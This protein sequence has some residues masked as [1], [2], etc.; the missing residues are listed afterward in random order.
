MAIHNSKES[1]LTESLRELVEVADY[2]I[3]FRKDLAD[4]GSQGCYGYPAAIL[5]LNICDAIGQFKLGGSVRNHFNIL[6]DSGYYNLEL[7]NEEIKSIYEGY[8]CCL[9]HEAVLQERF[10][11]HIGNTGE[12]IFEFT[13]NRPIFRLVPF[14]ELTRIVVDQFISELNID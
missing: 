5:L 13:D 7:S 8:R 10:F 14:L 3:N 4:W 2:C 9:V 11:L 6:N 1:M 12:L